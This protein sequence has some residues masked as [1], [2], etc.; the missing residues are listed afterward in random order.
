MTKKEVRERL[1][2]AIA[3]RDTEISF[4][5][6]TSMKDI[7][8]VYKRIAR[9]SNNSFVGLAIKAGTL[10]NFDIVYNS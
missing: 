1:V 4:P 8:T 9:R 3:A 2:A 7:Y 6:N 10:P 5:E